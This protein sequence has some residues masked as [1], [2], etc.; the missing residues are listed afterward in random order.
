MLA[1]IAAERDAGI[2]RFEAAEDL[3]ALETAQT[4]ILGRKSTF[5]EVQR[6]LGPLGPDERRDVG[7]LANDARRALT[8]AYELRKAAL[9]AVAETAFLAGDS[10][11][12]TLPGRRP[13]QGSMHPLSIVEREL[14]RVFTSLG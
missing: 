8:D 4:A 5:S 14:V 3:A 9:N 12:L 7:K 1:T 10:L 11:D 13:R 6:S 2:A